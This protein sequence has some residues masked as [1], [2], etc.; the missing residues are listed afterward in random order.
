MSDGDALLAAVIANP[1]DDTPRLVYADWL[2]ENGQ[3]ERAEFIRLQIEQAR[4]GLYSPEAQQLTARQSQLLSQHRRAWVKPLRE[5]LPSARLEFS[6]GF[7]EDV[8]SEASHYLSAAANVHRLTPIRE[9]RLRNCP[10]LCDANRYASGTR[11]NLTVLANPGTHRRTI[12][13][14]RQ[15]PTSLEPDLSRHEWLILVWSIWSGPDRLTVQQ[16]GRVLQ[17]PV[18]IDGLRFALRPIDETDEFQTWCPQA[19]EY[20]SPVW[21]RLVDGKY[22]L[23][24][25]GLTPP[26]PLLAHWE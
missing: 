11:A 9:V 12:R 17:S 7:V 1:D 6:R 23:H 20:A 19:L 18:Q 2:D 25:V 5:V 10:R 3:A 26:D 15:A 16:F 22:E 14:L 4:I 8:E 24:H 21:I 13:L